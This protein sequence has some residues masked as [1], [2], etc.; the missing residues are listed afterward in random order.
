M[1][2]QVQAEPEHAGRARRPTSYDVA[3]LAGVSQSAVSRCFRTGSSIAPATRAKVLRAARE[4]GYQPNA[5]ASGLITKRSNMVAVIISNLTNLYYPEV[6]ASLSAK[7]DAQGVRVLL[8][9][10]AN[11][12]DVDAA[13][14]QVWR[15]RVD[16]AIAAAR[17]SPDQ[18]RRFARHRVPVVLYNR[19]GEEVSVATVCCDSIGGERLLVDGLLAAGHRRF[20]VIGGPEDSYVARQR[21]EGALARLA[22]AGITPAVT[23]GA[24]DHD[25]G[26]AGL[27]RLMTMSDNRL[28]A[29]VCANDL[30]AIGAID[31]AREVYGLN[32]P[33]QLSIVGFDGVSP[34][35][36][37]SYR[38]TTVR[39][40]VERM[41]DAAV[42]MLMERVA[43]PD[44]P[45]EVRTFAGTFQPGGSAR[46]G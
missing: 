19:F 16:G 29:V 32:V 45:P 2:K 46:L 28:D 9:A 30:M 25:S 7:L 36:W 20:G 8:F 33:R 35:A 5:I 14:D 34:A 23:G 42:A 17:L 4:L 21:V 37:A 22:E 44:L 13:L 12:G 18:L 41:T 10:L 11:E 43:D 31:A 3:L 39:Q 1:T 26:V 40:P 27:R 38:L 24:F 15:Y 6:L